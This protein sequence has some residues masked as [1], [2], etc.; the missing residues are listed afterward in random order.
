[1]VQRRIRVD[2]PAVQAIIGHQFSDQNLGQVALNPTIRG[3]I[4]LE[5]LGD[6]ILGLVTFT[7]TEA[8]GYAR[9]DAKKLVSNQR[10]REIFEKLIAPYSP[11]NTG[12]VMEALVGAAYLDSGFDCASEVI[13]RAIV[14]EFG[15][16]DHNVISRKATTF[17]DRGL[18]FIGA[19]VS[20]AVVAEHLCRTKPQSNHEYFSRRRSELLRA[21]RLG[22]RSRKLGLTPPVK[23]VQATRRKNELDTD[24]LDSHVAQIFLSKGWDCARPEIVKVLRI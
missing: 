5:F 19:H 1:V 12:D 9:E 17:A 21:T 13:C 20:S 16:F 11:A 23:T 10:L 4:R 7:M 15:K 14:T 3:F 6:A 2:L 24:R 22:P 8:A 18:K